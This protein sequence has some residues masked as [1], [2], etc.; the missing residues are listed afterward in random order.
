M[1]IVLIDT[2]LPCTSNVGKL[3]NLNFWI[4]LKVFF[5]RAK[6]RDNGSIDIAY[7]LSNLL[8]GKP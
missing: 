8:P 6:E 1:S 3:N 2:S 7:V 4:K 5:V